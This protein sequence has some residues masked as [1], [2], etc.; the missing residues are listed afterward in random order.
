[1]E[2][3]FRSGL[4]SDPEYQVLKSW[5]EWIEKNSDISLDL[6]GKLKNINNFLNW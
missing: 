3:A 2:N 1:M 4:L 5:Y 6:I